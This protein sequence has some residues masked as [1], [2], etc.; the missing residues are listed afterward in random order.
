VIVA[1]N[2][3]PVGRIPGNDVT[4]DYRPRTYARMTDRYAT[5]AKRRSAC[6]VRANMI[7]RDADI[8]SITQDR[9]DDDVSCDDGAWRAVGDGDTAIAAEG[10]RACCVNA[11]VVISHGRSQS[12]VNRNCACQHVVGR[13]Y[14]A[15]TKADT[16]SEQGGTAGH[17]STDV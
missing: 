8:S 3:Q 2:R 12:E 4:R 17:V 16:A 1:S 5:A 13:I 9:P 14:R 7:I 6:G 15:G 10:V 11:D